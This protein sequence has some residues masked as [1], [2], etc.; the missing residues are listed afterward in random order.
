MI[1]RKNPHWWGGKEEEIPK[2]HG[3]GRL[4]SGEIKL[5]CLCKEGKGLSSRR[6]EKGENGGHAQKEILRPLREKRRSTPLEGK[7]SDC[8]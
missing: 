1:P 7:K 2:D 3:R 6:R 8:D 4:Y 5:A